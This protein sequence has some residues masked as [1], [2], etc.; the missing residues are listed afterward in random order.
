MLSCLIKYKEYEQSTDF[1]AQES[2]LLLS[3]LLR[4]QQRGLTRV[5]LRLIL[6]DK[7]E[8]KQEKVSICDRHDNHQSYHNSS[9]PAVSSWPL[10]GGKLAPA[11]C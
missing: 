7:D 11:I 6:K 3:C 8:Y 2:F 10:L 9:L 5:I 1:V 4:Q